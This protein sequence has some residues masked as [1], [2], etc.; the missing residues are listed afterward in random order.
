MKSA[1]MPGFGTRGLSRY[2]CIK[3]NNNLFLLVIFYR[4]KNLVAVGGIFLGGI[5]EEVMSVGVDGLVQ[6]CFER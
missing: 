2:E 3:I 5:Y 4:D 1:Q 6:P